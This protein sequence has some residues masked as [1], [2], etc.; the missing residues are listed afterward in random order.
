VAFFLL[1]EY[2]EMMVTAL[3]SWIYFIRT[4]FWSC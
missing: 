1:R 2:T 3:G 4:I